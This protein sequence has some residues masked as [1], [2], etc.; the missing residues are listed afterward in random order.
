L[1]FQLFFEPALFAPFRAE[2][3]IFR[4]QLL[5]KL[6]NT[7]V[8][9]LQEAVELVAAFAPNQPVRDAPVEVARGRAV[10]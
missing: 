7:R 9:M 3:G 1:F 10:L 6:P 4:K 2:A 5:G 8:L